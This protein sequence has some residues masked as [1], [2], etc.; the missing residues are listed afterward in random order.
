MS[1]VFEVTGARLRA[2]REYAGFSLTRMAQATNYSKSYLGLVETG[3]NA[4]TL[5]VVVAYE[6]VLGSACIER[7]SIT[8]G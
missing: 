8:R 7:T 5:Q 3:V 4:V 2:A 1:Q 6:R